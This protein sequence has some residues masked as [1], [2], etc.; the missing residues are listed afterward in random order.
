MVENQNSD[1]SEEDKDIPFEKVK[2]YQYNFKPKAYN[3]NQRI[4]LALI[5]F[6]MN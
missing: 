4:W 2:K 3:I 1:S 6:K 5:K